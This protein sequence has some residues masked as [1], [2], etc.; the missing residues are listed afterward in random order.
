MRYVI[1][2][3]LIVAS[4]TAFGQQSSDSI[5]TTFG[6]YD[7]RTGSYTIN[8]GYVFKE[9]EDVIIGNGSDIGGSYK[10]INMGNPISG[11]LHLKGAWAGSKFKI[12]EIFLNG[13]KKRGYVAACKIDGGIAIRYFCAIDPAIQSG[14][15]II[16]DKF[17]KK[18][19]DPAPSSVADELLKLKKLMDDGLLTRE[20]FDAQK[21]K[22]LSQ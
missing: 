18:G 13:D 11:E 16:P 20:E 21:K 12:R 9:G 6:I 2:F 22:L 5:K 3:I 10:Y 4:I 15:I 8:S 19:T 1:F 14:E 7:R 17:L